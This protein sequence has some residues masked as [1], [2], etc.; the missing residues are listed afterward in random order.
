MRKETTEIIAV[1]WGCGAAAGS[2]CV[3]QK[4]EQVCVDFGGKSEGKEDKDS[5]KNN[6]SYLDPRAS[7]EWFNF[8]L[9]LRHW[10]LL[11]VVLLSTPSI[12]TA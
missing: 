10:E 11:L 2:V 3:A 9:G 5:I 1:I 4:F 12:N 8:L 6:F 7:S